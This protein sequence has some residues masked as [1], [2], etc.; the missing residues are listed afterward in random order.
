MQTGKVA[1]VTGSGRGIGAATAK[2]L[3]ANG[4]AVC[5]SYKANEESA[6]SV[7]HSIRQM[8]GRC[9]SVKADVSSE[10]EVREL[11]ERV[12]EELGALSCLVNNVGI[13]AKQCR[14]EDM[15]T[16]RIEKIFKTNVTS[17]F[18]CSQQA[19]KRMS[20]QRGG[21]GGAIINVSSLASITGSPNEYIDYASS[22]GAID[23]FTRG[24]AVEV[25]A[26]GVRV[27][28]VRPGLIY[29]DI[30]SDGGEP[31]R[32]ERLKTKIPMQR[33]G[34]PEE[35]AEAVLWLASE[36]SSFVTGAFIDLSGGL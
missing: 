2:L 15:S 19:L 6:V 26:E 20:K 1:I 30:H 36:K 10:N 34:K 11:F 7:E 16:A 5:I 3:A 32:V 23:T 35:V 31:G 24:L 14:L 27:N 12:D 8:G 21:S 25:A 9:I 4:Y 33:G 13:L 28:C 18:M 17:Y 29:T 22:K